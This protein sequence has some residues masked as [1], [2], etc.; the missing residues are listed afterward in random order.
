MGRSE[1]QEHPK[2]GVAVGAREAGGTLRAGP[3]D[4]GASSGEGRVGEEGR[5]RGGPEHLKKK[6]TI[7]EEFSRLPGRWICLTYS[8]DTEFLSCAAA[9]WLCVGNLRD[10][11]SVIAPQGERNVADVL[12][13]V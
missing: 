3:L 13:V 10:A 9:F 6:I 8:T 1:P 5:C 4:G 12:I 7:R 2:R 11:V